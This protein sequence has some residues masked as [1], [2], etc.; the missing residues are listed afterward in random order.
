MACMGSHSAP[1]EKSNCHVISKRK[2]IKSE[3]RQH[4]S[5]ITHFVNSLT[6]PPTSP[7]ALGKCQLIVENID[8]HRDYKQLICI[9]ICVCVCVKL[10]GNFGWLIRLEQETP[11]LFQL[12]Y[13]GI[14]CCCCCGCWQHAQLLRLRL[15]QINV[16]K[17]EKKHNK[18]D[19]LVVVAAAQYTVEGVVSFTLTISHVKQSDSCRCLYVYVSVGFAVYACVSVR[20]RADV[21]THVL[22]L[23]SNRRFRTRV[24]VFV[25]IVSCVTNR[26]AGR[27]MQLTNVNLPKFSENFPNYRTRCCCCVCNS[28]VP[29]DLIVSPR[30]HNSLNKQKKYKF[31]LLSGWE[32]M[33]LQV[34]VWFNVFACVKDNKMCEPR[35]KGFFYLY[36]S[37]SSSSSFRFAHCLHYVTS[38]TA[39]TSTTTEHQL[40][41]CCRLADF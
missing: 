40:L 31:N 17:Q 10:T 20:P 14:C 36:Y 9:C 37:F 2:S 26:Q 34:C 8:K 28:H 18:V 30:F 16:K 13:V 3:K 6:L 38:V 4:L 23:I 1:L 22:I 15:R 19:L 27:R 24:V 35:A 32:S 29:L 11:A 41:R 33:Q 39:A 7:K 5:G 12:E 25:F 21:F